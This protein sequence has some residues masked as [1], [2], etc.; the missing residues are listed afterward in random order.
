MTTMS[1]SRRWRST[2]IAR[3]VPRWRRHCFSKTNA[4]SH[5]RRREIWFTVW[6]AGHSCR[7]NQFGSHAANRSLSNTSELRS[8][9]YDTRTIRAKH[10]QTCDSARINHKSYVSVSAATQCRTL[11]HS[12]HTELCQ[13][14]QRRRTHTVRFDRC[15]AIK[16]ISRD[17]LA[18][19][20]DELEDMPYC[21]ALV[22]QIA[23]RRRTEAHRQR[24][25]DNFK[26]SVDDMCVASRRYEEK[27]WSFRK[28]AKL[29]NLPGPFRLSH[30][31][32]VSVLQHYSD[33]KQGR[34]TAFK[35]YTRNG[36]L[37]KLQQR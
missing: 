7:Y 26:Y 32:H 35:R 9:S 37:S 14:L 4:A 36:E 11:A 21:Y 27:Y 2:R 25:R 30:K 8:I 34:V 20:D 28:T 13:I 15:G 31:D 24:S 1:L 29:K 18:V 17:G 6:S 19:Y 12:A 22:Q 5:G 10:Q 33:Y 16:I 3:R 23:M